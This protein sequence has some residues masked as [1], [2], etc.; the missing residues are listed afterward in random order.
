MGVTYATRV[1]FDTHPSVPKVLEEYVPVK[2][3][4]GELPAEWQASPLGREGLVSRVGS[5]ITPTGGRKVYKESGRPFVRSQNVGWGRLILDD[6]AYIDEQTHR[7]FQASEIVEGDVFLNITGASIGRC[8]VANRAVARGNVNQHVCEI[9]VNP[10]FMNPVFVSNVILSEIGQN[11]IASF[12]AGG[13][14]QG[15]NF[16]QVRAIVLP[17]PPL[18][19]QRAIATALSDVDS[20]IAALNALIAKKRAIKQAT[21]QQLLTGKTRLRGFDGE[22]ETKKIGEFTDCT[23]GGTPDTEVASYWNGSIRWMSS[24]ELHAKGVQ[25]V[26]GRITEAGLKNSSTKI[27]PAQCVL[28]GLAGQGKTRGTVAINTVPLCTNQSIAAIYPNA[29]F[30]TAYLFYNLESRYDELR[31]LSTGDG[32]RGGLNLTIIR[33]IKVPFPSK[34]EQEAI[35]QVLSDMDSEIEA[36]E[37]RVAKTRDIKQGMMQQL[38]TGRIRLVIPAEAQE[39]ATP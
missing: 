11:Q 5:G 6:L 10:A 38:L 7:S 35:A 27:V 14:R 29:S 28:V 20:L 22:W 23:A 1:S 31:E 33:A 17:L 15:L 19:E 25:E 32:G 16:S 18:P 26:A 36:L 39:E 24:G 30:D 3:P 12:Q 9:R 37:A 2:T 4:L 34:E 21:M 13:N 8:A